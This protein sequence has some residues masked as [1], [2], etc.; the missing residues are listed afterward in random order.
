[1]LFGILKFSY[2]EDICIIIL[3]LAD[4]NT[5]ILLFR[6]FL[7]KVLAIAADLYYNAAV[8]NNTKCDTG[9][10]AIRAPSFGIKG[11]NYGRQQ[12]EIRQQALRAS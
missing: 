6:D 11:E 10:R 2:Q 9:H 5:D 7:E 4:F 3:L 1:M 8:E 12:Q